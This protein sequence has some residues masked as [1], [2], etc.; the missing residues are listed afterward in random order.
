MMT[1]QFPNFVKTK[2]I[3]PRITKHSKQKKTQRNHSKEYLK[4][5]E[6]QDKQKIL[7]ES[8]VKGHI[9]QNKTKTGK[10]KHFSSEII[11]D[12]TSLKC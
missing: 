10:T 12:M 11:W 1:E 5:A 9:M 2:F 6:N 8:K 7:M 4:I 3:G